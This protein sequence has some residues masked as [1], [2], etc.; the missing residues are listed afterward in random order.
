MG[1]IWA[2]AVYENTN[3]H[4]PQAYRSAL[5]SVIPVAVAHS[6]YN[7]IWFWT[8]DSQVGIFTNGLFLLALT[9][10][11]STAY[12]SMARRSAYYRF[13]YSESRTAIACIKAGIARHPESCVLYRRLGI[14]ALADGRTSL[15][16]ESLRMALKRSPAASRRLI[17]F[18]YGVALLAAGERDTGRMHLHRSL[19]GLSLSRKRALERELR[20]ELPPGSFR[21]EISLLELPLEDRL[22]AQAQS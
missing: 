1:Y 2:G 8:A 20:E 4:N 17:R 21:Q 15:A 10:V 14:Y 7:S 12:R 18:F 22:G 6:L 13:R 19:A 5:V 11:V 16:V 3:R 9:A